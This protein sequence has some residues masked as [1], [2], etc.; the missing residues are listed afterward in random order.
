MREIC[1]N[2]LAYVADLKS[3]ILSAA[4]N[5]E[6]DAETPQ[7]IA[8]ELKDIILDF[9]EFE[10]SMQYSFEQEGK[11]K[12]KNRLDADTLASTRKAI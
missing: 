11:G 3:R 6:V 2:D 12:R 10:K 5:L 4:N 7:D 9:I 8:E 1:L